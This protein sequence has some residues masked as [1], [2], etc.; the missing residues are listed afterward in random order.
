MQ[1]M[2]AGVAVI[3]TL[4]A[5]LENRKDALE[6]IVALDDG[7]GNPEGSPGQHLG[8]SSSARHCVSR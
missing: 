5:A 4:V 2:A 7:S 8:R 6:V 3:E 1:L